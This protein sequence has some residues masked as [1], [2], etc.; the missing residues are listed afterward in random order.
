VAGLIVGAAATR[1]LVDLAGS[2]IPRAADIGLGWRVFAFLAVVCLVT[3]VAFGIAP[4]LAAMAGDVQQ[5]LKS[6]ERGSRSHGRVR[7]ALVV[8]E[9]ALALM[10]LIGAGLLL[11]T[12]AHLVSTPPGFDPSH[13]LTVHV[14]VADADESLRLVSRVAAIPG[15]DAAGF[16]SLLPLQHA[17]WF[18]RFAIAGGA[19]DGSAEFRYVTPGYFQAMGIP[20][21]RGRGL[22]DAD[23]A[24]RPR[25]LLINEALARRYF[26]S[27]DPV[28]RVLTDRGTIVGV[29]GDVRQS[30]LDRPAD[31]EIYYPV[32]QNFAQ[33]GSLGS[34]LVV[35]SA[36][37]AQSLVA[38][39]RGAVRE[40][41]P[42]Q[43]IFRVE[44]LED[45]V[46]QSIGSHRLYLW[47]LGVFAAI[48]TLLAA[49]G[50]YG[51]MAYLVT[52]RTREFGIRMA[53][54]ADRGRVVRLVVGRGGALLGGW[55][56]H[57]LAPRGCARP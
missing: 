50:I 25:V 56:A 55:R 29:V 43:A 26:P 53:L 54:G 3:G 14:A 44:T 34:T 24:E 42:G 7:D 9:V 37:P 12:F 5:D 10:L 23:T 52:L 33:L 35:R 8:A 36:L 28:G 16:I 57:L 27:E 18:G 19:G 32:A 38:A 2:Q 22:T 40:V 11:R 1:L 6:G 41:Q 30:R 51:V 21:R 48:G 47:L 45:V 15:V 20:I 39:I 31:P 49:T 46:R 13:V 4:A 17:N